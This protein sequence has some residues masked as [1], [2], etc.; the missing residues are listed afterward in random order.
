[1]RRLIWVNTVCN[2]PVFLDTTHIV[3]LQTAETDKTRREEMES[4][5]CVDTESDKSVEVVQTV[6]M[7]PKKKRK[8]GKATFIYKP[9]KNKP[10][11]PKLL[12]DTKL[13]LSD[14]DRC[15]ETESDKCVE[16]ESD[17]CAEMESDKCVDTNR[18]N[19]LNCTSELSSVSLFRSKL[20]VKLSLLSVKA[21][22]NRGIT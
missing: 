22:G 21:E 7:V 12:D 13:T 19:K 10:R 17:T 15:V 4:D 2:C 11:K 8:R 16:A 14:S 5:K 18:L 20:A 1:M 6:A 3:Y 9:R